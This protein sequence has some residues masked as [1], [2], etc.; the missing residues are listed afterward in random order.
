MTVTIGFPIPCFEHFKTY[1][2]TSKA[3]EG[4]EGHTVALSVGSARDY[5]SIYSP[6]EGVH[7]PTIQQYIRS[8]LGAE[9]AQAGFS[10]V[11][12]EY[13]DQSSLELHIDVTE[14]DLGYQNYYWYFIYGYNAS[15]ILA[16]IELVARLTVRNTGA[17]YER[18]FVAV[19][20][21]EGKKIWVV[22]APIPID[23]HEDEDALVDRAAHQVFGQLT[24]TLAALAQNHGEGS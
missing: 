5:F 22:Y 23:L 17:Q 21:S 14:F 6:E 13:A 1:Q 4:T 7:N 3:L 18:R 24:R 10:V 16:R 2:P 8:S 9:L 19:T 20:R 15:E 11:D 12:G